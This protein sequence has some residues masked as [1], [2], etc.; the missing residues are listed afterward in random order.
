MSRPKKQC[1]V[2]D[3]ENDH[4][5]HGLCQMHYLRVKRYGTTSPPVR[6]AGHPDTRE[7]I[8]IIKASLERHLTPLCQETLEKRLDIL[9]RR[10]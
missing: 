4:N 2:D 9:R 1:V 6:E 7:V 3:C 8:R 10:N 5:A